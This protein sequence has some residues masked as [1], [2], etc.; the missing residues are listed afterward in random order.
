L[1][2]RCLTLALALFQLYLVVICWP[3]EHYYNIHFRLVLNY[4][5]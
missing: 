2:D 3:N 1:I 5:L 4:S